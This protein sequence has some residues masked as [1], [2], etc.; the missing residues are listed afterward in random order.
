MEMAVSGM[1][2]FQSGEII[3]PTQKIYIGP[4]VEYKERKIAYRR[5]LFFFLNGR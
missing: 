4:F 5:A 2:A 1:D 3:P